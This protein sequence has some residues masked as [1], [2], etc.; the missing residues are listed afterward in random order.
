MQQHKAL[1]TLHGREVNGYTI[2]ILEAGDWGVRGELTKQ[3]RNSIPFTVTADEHQFE[4]TAV[5][6]DMFSEFVEAIN[7]ALL[8]PRGSHSLKLQY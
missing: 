6:N 7:A 3:S 5:L 2:Q 4:V 8:G 1:S